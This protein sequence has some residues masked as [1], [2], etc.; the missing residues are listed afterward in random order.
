M[1]MDTI[2][3]HHDESSYIKQDVLLVHMS[4]LAIHVITVLTPHARIA[5][6]TLHVYVLYNRSAHTHLHAHITLHRV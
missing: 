6:R 3:A 4:Y 2:Q 5:L 1:L